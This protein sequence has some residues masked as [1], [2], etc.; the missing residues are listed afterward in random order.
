MTIFH[1]R[2]ASTSPPQ[3]IQLIDARDHAAGYQ[4]L[5][6]TVAARLLDFGG[7][8]GQTSATARREWRSLLTASSRKASAPLWIGLHRLDDEDEIA[9]DIAWALEMGAEGVAL[10]C[11]RAGSD[12]QHLHVLLDVAE[13]E[14]AGKSRSLSILA[15]AG[16]N[17]TGLLAAGSFAKTSDRLVAI[18][19]H[20]GRLGEALRDDLRT[21][22]ALVT[23][24]RTTIRLAAA[25][26]GVAAV[27]WTCDRLID[28]TKLR[29]RGAERGFEWLL[30]QQQPSS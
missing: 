30:V 10:P 28:D 2:S 24:V 19:W 26:A 22:A 17:P 27:D 29:S 5:A 8:D 16:D 4:H 11:A 13:A 14:W 1:Q 6:S 7:C 12:L 25:A 21:D 15:M 9:L 23:S 20:G 18:G 3:I